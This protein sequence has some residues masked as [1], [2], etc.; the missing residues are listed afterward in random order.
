[1]LPI[2]NLNLKLMITVLA[3]RRFDS[4]VIQIAEVII[5]KNQKQSLIVIGFPQLFMFMLVSSFIR[6][7][8]D[9]NNKIFVTTSEMRL[10][11]YTNRIIVTPIK[12]FFVIIK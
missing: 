7:K 11:S 3:N 2:R 5:C 8:T 9:K 4:F 6:R 10:I 12:T 1:M